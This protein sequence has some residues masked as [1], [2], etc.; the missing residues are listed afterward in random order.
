MVWVPRRPDVK[1]ERSWK[2][3]SCCGLADFTNLALSAATGA[4]RTSSAPKPKAIFRMSAA[5]QFPQVNLPYGRH[6]ATG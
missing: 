4:A 6:P 3:A 1:M 5:S 2:S